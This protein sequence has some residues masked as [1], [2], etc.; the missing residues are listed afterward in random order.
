[1]QQGRIF[2]VYASEKK[3]LSSQHKAWVC[4]LTHTHLL[5]FRFIIIHLYNKNLSKFHLVLETC[6]LAL[7]TWLMKTPWK[8]WAS[9]KCSEESWESSTIFNKS[10]D[11]RNN[12]VDLMG[13]WTTG[14]MKKH[15]KQCQTDDEKSKNR[16][17]QSYFL[18]WLILAKGLTNSFLKSY[19]ELRQDLY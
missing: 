6:K 18:L 7:K 10:L 8:I 11:Q 1:M 14:D 13:T 9:N 4:K 17:N 5:F 2:L 15:H 19:K 3:L 16:P 12:H